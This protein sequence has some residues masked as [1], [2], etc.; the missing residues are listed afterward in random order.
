VTGFSIRLKEFVFFDEHPERNRFTTGETVEPRADGIAVW[1]VIPHGNPDLVTHS[2]SVYFHRA[3]FV[4]NPHDRSNIWEWDGNREAP[5]LSPSILQT[6]EM[7]YPFRLHMHIR[8]GRIELLGD[9][10][11]TLEEAE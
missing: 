4:R 9:S 10:T 5:T 11:V 7:G 1:E 8:S 2:Q 6:T 3:G